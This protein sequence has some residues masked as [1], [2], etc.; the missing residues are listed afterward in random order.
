MYDK[1]KQDEDEGIS[2]ADLEGGLTPEELFENECSKLW[3]SSRILENNMR[4]R[5]DMLEY[6]QWYYKALVELGYPNDCKCSWVFKGV[7]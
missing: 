7:H 5:D 4:S 3:E 6:T 1:L 2:L